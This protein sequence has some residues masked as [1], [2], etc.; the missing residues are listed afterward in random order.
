V[1]RSRFADYT[2]KWV[3]HCHILL[4]EDFGMMQAVESVARPEDTNYNPRTRLASHAMTPDD[5]SSIYPRP[6]REL[7]YRQSMQFVDVSPTCGQVFPG[8]DL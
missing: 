5:V 4:H 2:G 1:Y 3:N 6:S 7:M 8:F